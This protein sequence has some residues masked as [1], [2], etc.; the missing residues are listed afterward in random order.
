ML[1]KVRVFP[2]SKTNE[3]IKKSEDSFDMKIRTKPEKGLANKAVISVLA[4]YFK[5]PAAK[6]RMVKGAKQRNK[7]FEVATG[8]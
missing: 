1:V 5:V 8:T 2:K 6:I 7:I 3:I 4:S